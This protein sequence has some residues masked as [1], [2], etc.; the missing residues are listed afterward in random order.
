MTPKPQ[1]DVAADA[2]DLANRVAAWIASRIAATRGRF[3]LNLSGGSTPKRV[4]QLLGRGPFRSQIDWRKLELFWGDERFV[5]FDHPNSNY[6]MTSEALLSHVPIAPAQIHPVPTDA[7][8]PQKAAALYQR[9][10]QDFYGTETL[11][12]ER[13]LFDVTLLGL[14]ADGH[15]ASLFPDTPA[16]DERAAWATAVVGATPEPRISMTYPVIESSRDILFLVSGGEKKEILARVLSGDRALPAARLAT[17]GTIHIFADRA[18][19][20]A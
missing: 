15:T 5:P 17:R 4:Y 3:V 2:D 12:P 20:A 1:I 11:D 9:S 7:G 16:L 6:R 18:A 14:G 19:V 13:P 10:L 8:S